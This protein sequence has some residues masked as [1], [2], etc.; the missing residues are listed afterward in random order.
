MLSSIPNTMHISFHIIDFFQLVLIYI[1]AVYDSFEQAQ[2][3]EF[4]FQFFLQI[5]FIVV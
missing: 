1:F 3:I 2:F 4:S 5:L